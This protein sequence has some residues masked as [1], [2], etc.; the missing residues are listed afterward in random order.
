MAERARL[1][2]GS[3]IFV[4]VERRRGDRPAETAGARVTVVDVAL[5]ERH[6]GTVVFAHP[7]LLGSIE[8]FRDGFSAPELG[9]PGGE[10]RRERTFYP[11]FR[12]YAR[13]IESVAGLAAHLRKDQGLSVSA[14][15]GPIASAIQLDRNV[16]AVLDAIV[17]LAAMGLA[18]SLCAI[19]W[20]VAI[21]KRRVVAMLNLMG[22]GERWLVG[23][24]TVQASV[25]AVSGV[26]AAV[27]LA[28]GAAGWINRNFAA[29]FGAQGAACVIEPSLLVQGAAAVLLLSLLPAIMI[30]IGFTR[31][32]PSDEIRDV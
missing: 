31:V 24:P 19:Q 20:A 7:K 6:G 13:T 14:Q 30:G 15:E 8:A 29:S 3:E 28:H 5:P 16:R 18:G 11:N 23:F 1:A 10:A 27:L 26:L 4:D 2:A 32:D 22:Y 9:M 12:L 25:L 21:R 17:L